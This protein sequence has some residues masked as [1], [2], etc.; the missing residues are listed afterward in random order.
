MQ[1]WEDRVGLR[2]RTAVDYLAQ[3]FSVFLYERPHQSSVN[4]YA[5]NT[6]KN[7]AKNNKHSTAVDHNLITYQP[8]HTPLWEP[9]GTVK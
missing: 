8:C 7:Q 2:R 3:Y 4:N 6:N 5:W 1:P 9:L